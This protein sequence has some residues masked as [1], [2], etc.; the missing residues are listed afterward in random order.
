MSS[1]DIMFPVSRAQTPPARR[2]KGET[3]ARRVAL[4]S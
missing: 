1:D 4:G 2:E 3:P